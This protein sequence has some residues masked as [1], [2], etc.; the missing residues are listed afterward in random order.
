[1]KR[2]S[3]V[4]LIALSL[5]ACEKFSTDLIT[6]I[7]EANKVEVAVTDLPTEAQETLD[8]LYFETYTEK[9]LYADKLG[10][11][12]ELS[13]LS[14]VFFDKNGDQLLDRRRGRKGSG[15]PGCDRDSTLDIASLP[16]SITSYITTNYPDVTIERAKLDRDGNF[17]VKVSGQLILVFDENGNFVEEA[18]FIHRQR[19]S[20]IDVADLPTVIT[21]YIAS[22]YA[23]ATIKVA[24]QK[25]KG[26]AVGIFENDTRMML[27]FDA[28][29]NFVTVKTCNGG[30]G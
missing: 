21:D 5:V 24:F 12:V 30:H 15:K 3:L 10:Y 11:Q 7:F 23:S 6:Q 18:Q 14:K 1:M 8:D 27:L 29:G 28:E 17:L 25:D 20:K 9:V 26:Y 4:T 2:W 16:S 19:G 22:N 13:N